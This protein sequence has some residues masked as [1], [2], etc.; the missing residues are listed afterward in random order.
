MNTEQS[1]NVIESEIAGDKLLSTGDLTEAVNQFQEALNLYESENRHSDKAR[2]HTKLG[3]LYGSIQ[4][5]ENALSN[6]LEAL[7]IQNAH[8][9]AVEIINA[10]ISVGHFYQGLFLLSNSLEY[11]TIALDGAIQL[12]S[13]SL[14]AECRYSLGNCLN[15]MERLEEAGKQLSLALESE[16]INDGLKMRILGSS[17]ILAYKQG[18][19]SEALEFF[20]ESL[21]IN[22]RT[23]N[24]QSF[25][26]SVL[27]S[28]GMAYFLENQKG[29]A[30]ECLS[31]SMSMANERTDL[32]TLTTIHEHYSKIYESSGDYKIA[33][34]HLK[35]RIELADIVMGEN[36][37][38]KTRELQ[39]RY[40]ISESQREKEIYRLKNIDLVE[41][42]E[43]IN[44]QKAELQSKNRQ[45]TDSLYYAGRLQ[46][47]VLPSVNTLEKLLKESFVYFQ[48][49]DIVSGDFYWFTE[50]DDRLLIAAV[51]CTGHGVPGALLSMMGNNL[52]NECVLKEGLIE[53]AAILENLNQRTKSLLQKHGADVI[54]NDGMD[55]ALC[56]ID[57]KNGL[58]SFAGAHRPLIMIRGGELVETKGS[59]ISI[60]G[61]SDYD[62]G[63]EQHEIAIEE[64]DTFYIFSDGYPDQFGGP[65]NRKFMSKRMKEFLLATSGVPLSEQYTLLKSELDN[66]RF[67]REQVDDILVIGFR[68]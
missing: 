10:Q 66:W 49:K 11:F 60:G 64:G 14:I 1:P 27:K 25:K 22:E 45:I 3:K 36:D 19:S 15:W 46:R 53:P 65:D 18:R 31:E 35:K 52:L 47:A 8:G 42:N 58:L 20:K 41:A 51:D 17:G 30:L 68:P 23:A 26:T 39:K 28:M 12:N 13:S 9:S 40:D 6:Y 38:L 4:D 48:P 33:L 54:A 32:G 5:T 55:V 24:N 43:E 62:A 21:E 29:K 44:R 50:K 16:E 37:K 7:D 67:G 59:R 57:K 61:Y 56:S 63:F 34:D 2:V